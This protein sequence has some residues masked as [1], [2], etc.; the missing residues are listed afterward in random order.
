MAKILI[1][2]IECHTFNFKADKGFMICSG[3]EELGTG[4]VEILQRDNIAKNPLDDRKL[5]L[6]IKN[7]ILQADML[8]THN[9]KWFDL[10]WLNSRLVHWGYAPLPSNFPHFDTCEVAYKKMRVR[11][12]LEALGK[13][14]GCKVKKTETDMNDWLLAGGGN[15]RAQRKIVVHNIADVKLTKEVYLK[16]RV[17]GFKHPNLASINNEPDQCPLCEKK[18]TLYRRGWIYGAVNKSKRYECR[19]EKGGCGGWS[20]KAYRKSGIEI[21]P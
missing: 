16:M 21:R 19:R 20:H 7:R 6:A 11:N 9:G 14:L 10:P 8:V 15:Q 18:G 2:D 17:F 1:W 13:F 4:K 3:F 5:V 12:S